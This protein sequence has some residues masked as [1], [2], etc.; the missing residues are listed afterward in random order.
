MIYIPCYL[1]AI[2]FFRTADSGGKTYSFA[3]LPC[4]VAFLSEL[5]MCMAYA[6]AILFIF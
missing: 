2:F 5:Q 1:L 6:L 3:I 4:A